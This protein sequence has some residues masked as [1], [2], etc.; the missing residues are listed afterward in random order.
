[1]TAPKDIIH[2]HNFSKVGGHTFHF[3][4]RQGVPNDIK[5][6]SDVTAYAKVPVAGMNVL[7]VGAHIGCY[8]VM[9]AQL[10]AAHVTAIEPLP[11]NY[12]LL[13]MNASMEEPRH[14]H[15][16]GAAMPGAWGPNHSTILHVKPTPSMCSVHVRGGDQILVPTYY[17]QALL[18]GRGIHVIKLDCEGAEYGLL[19]DGG[20]LP[21]TVQSMI[22]ELH[23]GRKAWRNQQ[24]PK[25]IDMFRDWDCLIEPRIGS[26][27]WVTLGAWTR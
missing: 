11:D 18:H 4:V 13:C 1:M 26:T 15:I 10:G 9:A 8:S 16:W 25:V 20:G 17:W 19:L 6:M 7:D 12:R 3:F 24:A 22:V 2:S 21:D 27:N 5:V 23:L 14:T